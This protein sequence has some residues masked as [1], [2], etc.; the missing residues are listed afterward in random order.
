[1][2]KLVVFKKGVNYAINKHIIAI[3]HRL[4]CFTLTF[5]NAKIQKVKIKSVT[6]NSLISMCRLTLTSQNN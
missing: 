2:Q 5:Q 3:L 1:M 4:C 6:L